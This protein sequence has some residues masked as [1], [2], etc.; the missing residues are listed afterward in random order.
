MV[1]ECLIISAIEQ[2]TALFNCSHALFQT[3]QVHLIPVI[4]ILM[5]SLFT[6]P[7]LV[8]MQDLLIK[9]YL[10]HPL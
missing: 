7:E 2:L 4:L 10:L 8:I 5:N 6:V 1:K 9:V 3:F